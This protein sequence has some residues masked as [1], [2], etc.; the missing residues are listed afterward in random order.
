MTIVLDSNFVLLIQTANRCTANAECS[1]STIKEPASTKHN[2]EGSIRH[3]SIDSENTQITRYWIGKCVIRFIYFKSILK[4]PES[5]RKGKE[6]NVVDWVPDEISPHCM[7]CGLK[8]GL[9]SALNLTG[10]HHCRLCGVSVCRDCCQPMLYVGLAGIVDHEGDFNQDD[11]VRVC[12]YCIN[13]VFK[14]KVCLSY[15]FIMY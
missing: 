3:T 7:N 8:F 14:L 13:D 10:R 4:L 6:Q 11:A 1:L 2:R 15:D 9:E 5:E 12:E